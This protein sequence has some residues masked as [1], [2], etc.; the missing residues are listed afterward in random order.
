VTSRRLLPYRS[1]NE[2]DLAWDS[3]WFEREGIRQP[4]PTHLPGWDY[5]S[6]ETIGVTVDVNGQAVLGSTGLSSLTTLEIVLVA[7]CPALG[8]R[9]VSAEPLTDEPFQRLE[10]A[11]EIPAGEVASKLELSVHLVLSAAAPRKPRVAS[12]PGARVGWSPRFNLHAEVNLEEAPW[13]LST[14]FVGLNDSFMGSVRLLI[15]DAHPLGQAV[16]G[17]EQDPV[18]AER[19]KLDVFRMLVAATSDEA[20][21]LS[22]SYDDDSVGAV[23]ASMCELYL[24]RTHV[25]TA[26]LYREEPLKFE[27]LCYQ[28]ISA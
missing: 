27:R 3:W 22:S 18:A 25:E 17:A 8:R 13:T 26:A 19:L 28:V 15:N 10:L 20:L 23:I 2:G 16:L 12:A 11:V 9:F 14:S 7:D 5:A 4:L 6:Q 21:E 1:I 24:R